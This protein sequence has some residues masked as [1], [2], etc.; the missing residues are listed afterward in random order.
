[1]RGIALAIVAQILATQQTTTYEHLKPLLQQ[2]SLQGEFLS[3]NIEYTRT[4]NNHYAAN[5]VALLL[6]GHSLHKISA[7]VLNI[8]SLREQENWSGNRTPVL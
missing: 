7:V 2:M 1:M 8:S 4:R 3:R 6:M 5:I